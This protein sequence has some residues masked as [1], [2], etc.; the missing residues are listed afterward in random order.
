ML[1]ITP[2]FSRVIVR[3][4]GTPDKIG[5]IFIPNTTKEMETT[6][7]IVE[8]VAEDCEKVKPGMSVYYG[9]YSGNDFE[10]NG[11]KYRLMNEEDVLGIIGGNNG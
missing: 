6:E 8:A 7:G 1:D 4:K 10:R 2:L 5:A 9:R 11:E 3:P